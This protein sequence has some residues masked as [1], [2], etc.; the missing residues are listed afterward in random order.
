[1]IAAPSFAVNQVLPTCQVKGFKNKNSPG[2]LE[3]PLQ[4]SQRI[5]ASDTVL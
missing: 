2:Q 5:P 1:V 3:H 4:N